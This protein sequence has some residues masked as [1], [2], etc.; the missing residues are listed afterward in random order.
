MAQNVIEVHDLVKRYRRAGTNAVDRVSFDVPEAGLF[1]LLGPN[2]AGKTTTVSILTTTLVM[3]SGSV[4]IAG[5]DLAT[6]QAMVRDRVGIVFQGA[7][8]DLNLTA[9]E[10]VRIH[11]VL[12]GLY[13][14]RPFFR[15]MPRP[16]RRQV[17]EV[18]AVLGVG[19]VLGRPVRT[20]SGGTRRKLEIVRAL[21]HHPRVLFLD[22]P[23]VGLDPQSR[24][25]LWSYL[26]EARKKYQ[27][28]V[29]LTT[30]YLEEAEPAETVCVIVNG[31]V[32]EMG[33]PAAIKSR[34]QGPAPPRLVEPGPSLED[35]YVR[36]LESA[37]N[38]AAEP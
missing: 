24:R 32:V 28:T 22:E 4:L 5:K 25:S 30:H 13:P 9:E 18:A 17:D 3:T 1:C 36:L 23:T 37:Q 15:W 2:G 7:S 31:R 26:S 12:Y 35:A 21:M 14:W 11:A 20:L 19:D 8:L 29:F 34:H 27:T 38:R 10:N 33:S 6:Q 16:Y